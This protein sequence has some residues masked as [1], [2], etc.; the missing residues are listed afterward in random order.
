[1]FKIAIMGCGVVG[2]GVA[3]IL[4]EKSKEISRMFNRTIELTKILDIRDY[5]DT[6]YEPYMTKT[7]DDILCD[8]E[9]SLVVMTIGGNSIAYEL[10]K[11]ALES[12]KHVVTSNKEIV[13]AY[14]RELTEIAYN[15]DVRFMFEASAGGGIPIIRPLNICLAAND[16]YEIQ[17]I[18]NGTTNYILTK[19]YRDRLSFNEALSLAQQKGYAE[20]D[21]TADI[22]GHDAARKIAILSSI[23]YDKYVD[24]KEV[25]CS[26][27]R[28]IIFEDHE[29]ASK[30][31]YVIKLIA[32][33]IN[34]DGKISA[35]VEPLLLR[36]DHMLARVN[37]VFNGVL[38]KGSYTGDSM[39]Y[40]KGAGKLPTA[41]AIM[42]DVIEILQCP[43]M[44]SLPGYVKNKAVMNDSIE[45]KSRYFVRFNKD[46]ICDNDIEEI[47]K[48]TLGQVAFYCGKSDKD[49]SIAAFITGYVNGEELNKTIAEIT[50]AVNIEVENIIKLED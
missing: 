28:N 16:I 32:R 7:A 43:N 30:A 6:S 22:D 38:V 2:S 25:K 41:N 14:G 31:G 3:D 45:S 21:P 50:N 13:A 44:P 47:V 36:D 40:G 26:G 9:I 10:S 24:Y 17:G 27:I 42:G 12:G 34:K 11:K 15:N 29:L 46:S 39:F 20:A 19:M 49:I 8:P 4:L 33:S 48:N 18:L 5:K 35:S 37:S 23:A 1:M